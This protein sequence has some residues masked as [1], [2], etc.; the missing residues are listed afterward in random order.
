M[1]AERLAERVKRLRGETGC[2]VLLVEHDVP[3]VMSLCDRVVVLAF[4]QVL[5]AGT[6]EE[7]HGDERVQRAYLGAATTDQPEDLVE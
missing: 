6:P 7:I 2:S 5:A 3:F 4:G 1:E